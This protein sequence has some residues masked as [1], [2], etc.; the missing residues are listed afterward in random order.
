MISN[1]HRLQLAG[2]YRRI[3]PTS[4][5][6]ETSGADSISFTQ[7]VSLYTLERFFWSRAF[8]GK[9]ERDARKKGKHS[10]RRCRLGRGASVHGPVIFIYLRRRTTRRTTTIPCRNA[11]SLRSQDRQ[12]AAF[13]LNLGDTRVTTPAPPILATDSG[14]RV[15]PA[16][17]GQKVLEG[18]CSTFTCA[19]EGRNPKRNSFLFL[20]PQFEEL[21]SPNEGLVHPSRPLSD[22]L[23]LFG[24]SA[25]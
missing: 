3:R 25:S 24:A 17:S 7:G 9:V 12:I 23:L 14:K 1:R 10:K 15:S 2:P 6:C 8:S 5:A 20:G 21:I 22:T 11:G 4:R 13:A 18:V 16:K 19:I